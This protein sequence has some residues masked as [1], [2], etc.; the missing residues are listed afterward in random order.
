MP[1]QR[2]DVPRLLLRSTEFRDG[3]KIALRL[4]AR[5]CFQ[6]DFAGSYQ[7]IIIWQI[8]RIQNDVDIL[9]FGLPECPFDKR[10]KELPL[11]RILRVRN[12][13]S[14]YQCPQLYQEL[15]SKQLSPSLH[16]AAP[17]PQSVEGSYNA[18]FTKKQQAE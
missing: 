12:V 16:L 6:R 3:N 17:P 9:P 2:G 5:L 14:I 11:W 1:N 18:G 10:F 15:F 13:M 7:Q 4:E 8:G